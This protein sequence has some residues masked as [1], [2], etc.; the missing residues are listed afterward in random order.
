MVKYQGTW[1]C[2][3]PMTLNLVSNDPLCTGVPAS[4]TATPY[5]SWCY[6][7]TCASASPP[8][9][10]GRSIPLET[11]DKLT[12]SP[13]KHL[14]DVITPC[15]STTGTTAE[16]R[17][18]RECDIYERCTIG[19]PEKGLQTCAGCKDYTP[20]PLLGEPDATTDETLQGDG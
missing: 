10:M 9:P 5:N 20:D 11:V 17:H 18:I 1:A 4:V 6:P 12:R 19:A 13:C 7:E 2:C 8:P 16:A 3:S 14:G 15:G